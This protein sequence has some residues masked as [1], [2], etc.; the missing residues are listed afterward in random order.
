M[1]FGYVQTGGAS[2]ERSEGFAQTANFEAGDK[3]LNF[4]NEAI[5]IKIDV[6]GHEVNV[7]KGLQNILENNKCILQ[8]EIFKDKLD[9]NVRFLLH[10]NYKL[11]FE[12]KERNNY[13]FS[14]F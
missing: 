11:T 12:I 7:L 10:L 3:I 13:F 9:E 4:K 2:V 14:N 8:V 5:A 1:K 6:E